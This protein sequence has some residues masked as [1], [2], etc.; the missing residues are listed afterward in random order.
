VSTE[1][2][3]LSSSSAQG[4]YSQSALNYTAT[5][6]SGG[7]TVTSIAANYSVSATAIA[8]AM[9]REYDRHSSIDTAADQYV[10]T[11]WDTHQE[12]HDDYTA[13]GG[14]TGYIP[15]KSD[16][17]LY[18]C[19]NDL[20]WGNIKMAT[21]IHLIQSY[22]SQHVGDDPLN[23]MQ[24]GRNYA[25]NYNFLAVDLVSQS[26]P[27][28]A[29]LY[30]LMVAEAEDFFMDKA[31][32]GSDWDGL[33]Q[34][35]KDSLYVTYCVR[36][37]Q[38]ITN[39]WASN[40]ESGALP[41]EPIPGL[42]ESGGMSHLLNAP[43][44]GKALG[45][46]TYGTNVSAVN[47]NDFASLAQGIQG[48][49]YE[50][51]LYWLR[52]IA[53]T[54][55][56]YSA[57]NTEGELNNLSSNWLEDRAAML[58]W[59]ITVKINNLDGLKAGG[60]TYFSDEITDKSFG[61]TFNA[62]MV[63][64]GDSNQDE[65]LGGKKNDHLYGGA[66]ADTLFGNAGDDLLEGGEGNDI[67]DGGTGFNTLDG[68]TGTG[69]VFN[70]KDDF[71]DALI[72]DIDG[73]VI[74]INGSTLNVRR[75]DG[76]TNTDGIFLFVD[77]QGNPVDSKK[78]WF[79]SV[80]GSTL[81]LFLKNSANEQRAIIAEDF[82]W[83]D[84]NR[85]FGIVFD[86]A[87]PHQPEPAQ[88]AVYDVKDG[89]QLIKD[90]KANP[91]VN[92]LDNH[93]V[94]YNASAYQYHFGVKVD[95]K[96][97][98]TGPLPANAAISYF[99][100]G[101]NCSDVLNGADHLPEQKA[102]FKSGESSSYSRLAW[103]ADYAVTDS[104]GWFGDILYGFDGDDI[105]TGD[106]KKNGETNY[107]SFGGRD[108][109]VGGKGNDQIY[110][111]GGDDYI[112]ARVTYTYAEFGNRNELVFDNEKFSSFSEALY[113]GAVSIE[114]VGEQNFIDG[115]DGAD[116]IGGAS[117]KDMIDG[118]ND[119]DYVMAG[120]GCDAIMGGGGEDII[121]ADSFTVQVT[122]NQQARDF[123][124]PDILPG[125]ITG[126]NFYG[127][128]YFY[129]NG[130]NM[131][132]VFL[133]N[134]DYNDVI[135]GG[136]DN[137]LVFG[138][139]GADRISGGSG[140]DV[141]FG[142][143]PYSAGYFGEAAAG[144]QPLSSKYHG[145][146]LID[147]GIGIDFI[148]GGGGD[149][150]LLGG[151][152]DDTI[153]GDVGVNVYEKKAAEGVVVPGDPKDV[154]KSGDAGW[155]GKDF[156][157]GGDGYDTL[158][159]EGGDDRIDGGSEN[160]QLYGDWA[161]WQ[162][163]AFGN[164][165]AHGNDTLVG[166]TGNDML[167]GNGGKDTLEG[168]AGD[169]NLFGD[170]YTNGGSFSGAGD[171]LL[172][173]G[174]GSDELYGGGG[175]DELNGGTGSDY[176][177]GGADDDSYRFD[178]ANGTDVINDTRGNSTLY[179]PNKP[180]SA[181]LDKENMFINLSADGTNRIQIDQYSLEHV[182]NIIANGDVVKL[183]IQAPD[184]NQSD[185]DGYKYTALT[186]TNGDDKFIFSDNYA[187]QFTVSGYQ[188]EDT[189]QLTEKW[190]HDGYIDA[191][192]ISD[193]WYKTEYDIRYCSTD[194]VLKNHGTGTG[195][196]KLYEGDWQKYDAMALGSDEN[197]NLSVAN[198]NITGSNDRDVIRGQI[199]ND[200]IFGAGGTD[201]LFGGE[202]NDILSGG[203]SND[204]L[205]GEVGDDVLNGAD[206]SDL[207]Y[208]DAGDDTLSGNGEDY[209]YGGDGND[210]FYNGGLGN[211]AEGGTGS[212]VFRIQSDGGN[213]DIRD[214]QFD[215][216][217][218][219]EF[220]VTSDK[221]HVSATSIGILQADGADT[222]A[223]VFFLNDVP[224]DEV[225][226]R[227]LNLTVQFFDGE[228]WNVDVLKNHV[229]AGSSLGDYILGDA[230][231][232]TLHGW[233]GSDVMDGVA[234]ND[235]LFGDE[236]DDQLSGGV[237]NDTLNGGAGDDMLVGGT[238][239]D[240]F[241][242]GKNTG[243]DLV[244]EYMD[245]GWHSDA[246]V[247][248]MDAS[249]TTS[250]IIVA[251][252]QQDLVFGINNN[253]DDS[254]CLS[255]FMDGVT[256]DRNLSIQFA[257]ASK[258]NMERIER[259]IF[260]KDSRLAIYGTSS[261]GKNTITG[262]SKANY[263]F[264]D[265][266]DDTLSGGDNNDWLDGGA[267][268][269]L[270]NGGAGADTFRFGAGS[271]QDVINDKASNLSV[272]KIRLDYTTTISDLT[273]EVLSST[274]QL[275]ISRHN[276][277]GEN[278][279]SIL[280]GKTLGKLTDINGADICVGTNSQTG[281]NLTLLDAVNKQL[282]E[283]TIT[284]ATNTADDRYVALT[285]AEI[286]GSGFSDV[287][288]SRWKI[289]AATQ[290]SGAFS[291][292][293]FLENIFGNG[294]NYIAFEPASTAGSAGFNFT[295]QR[296]D[297]LTI[298]SGVIVNSLT[299]STLTGTAGND[300]LDGAESDIAL[301]INGA[302]GDDKLRDGY[303]NDV[304]RGGDGNDVLTYNWAGNGDDVYYGDAGNDVLDAGWGRDTMV[305]GAGNDTYIE[306]NLWSGDVTLIDN[307]TAAAGD[308][309]TLQIGLQGHGT[310]DY[311][312]LWFTTSG[313]DLL[314]GQIDALEPGQICI[315]NWF[316]T[317]RP[318]SKLDVIR[319]L[320]DDGNI[321]EARVDANF[322]ALVQAMAGFSPPSNVAGIDNSLLDEYNAAWT[323]AMP[324]AA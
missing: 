302:A 226:T 215:A 247:I 164:T 234:G 112:F 36:G 200:K 75:M 231:D 182:G 10:L 229:W 206:G 238:G 30:A 58:A 257:D 54:T 80:S 284:L 119:G 154:I 25:E 157:V 174:A 114:N 131:D 59:D 139:I 212:D 70:F 304:L 33:P 76:A 305:G 278:T 135:D 321:Y 272:D 166:G 49:A 15:S 197:G 190:Q 60:D 113:N 253:S 224:A 169:D 35:F 171:D 230:T 125:D 219:I 156:I 216:G 320:Q 324:A 213:L 107:E 258:W 19:Y 111:G 8:G 322:D 313:K 82:S 208:G 225:W 209:L 128:S 87:V 282:T 311:R 21:A 228:I 265:A 264:G 93:S 91:D 71:G 28:T 153:Y 262:D 187:G 261:S 297:G 286:L 158:I 301:T 90:S 307:S 196:I 223:N 255:S 11:I 260:S 179:L 40:T 68:G 281:K 165:A 43:D 267:G 89:L 294:I 239:N 37:R 51:A 64:F 316:D 13:I 210:I 194:Y 152:G 123:I 296:D 127:R 22:A 81:T 96:G 252:Q 110:G 315:K 42:G 185:D 138:E 189:I 92:P 288:V 287:E 186:G 48:E 5:S 180:L 3:F 274:S 147:G 134:R 115:G 146:D 97:N 120:S 2:C 236:G 105:I 319:V 24:V 121:Y 122:S 191:Y 56:D 12:W 203:D 1:V 101:A 280:V 151:K 26:N 62:N 175:K 243:H 44:I 323:L 124:A 98:I 100:E 277:A 126:Q 298:K 57:K 254:L 109:L 259:E 18:G 77:A 46:T 289:T 249:V 167:M 237:G 309:D 241:C 144:F 195:T 137:D 214:K 233:A 269:D 283:K 65:M 4:N 132:E 32:Y 155:W 140:N 235:R 222:Y 159:G 240:I 318:E 130:K 176:L 173:G 172:N 310:W 293:Y 242:F 41:Y 317:S 78:D 275:K 99:F 263:I 95:D 220:D 9:A 161:G 276:S 74:R 66:G 177:A 142:D 86:D 204:T 232:N 250:N 314:I 116:V 178:P 256:H 108:A 248:Q 271:G 84:P 106:G 163:E 198:L 201:Y 149:D 266:G 290:T 14:D 38:S 303:G 129:R 268:N 88:S 53:I 47:T 83:A 102:N 73:G 188:G 299:G 199:G 300:L 183:E 312:A 31:A 192:V 306:G 292:F 27:L 63:L 17:L 308:V 291:S 136:A 94:I 148:I 29:K 85:H 39:S 61:Y 279:D 251:H 69:D 118:G 143:R 227:M 221:V 162:G 205:H 273:I 72:H 218:T 20:G 67:L 202:G 193:R 168:G 34:E 246:D 55:L 16:K 50:Y 150:D 295:L 104:N 244:N 184:F 160:D 117:Y 170:N 133:P 6:F 270:L 52:P 245:T 207:L 285:A 211:Q 181:V 141:L 217:D 7:E 79:V 45:N 103:S 23:L 145:N